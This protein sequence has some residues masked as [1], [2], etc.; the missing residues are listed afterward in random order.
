MTTLK[1]QPGTHRQQE[2]VLQRFKQNRKLMK[3][4]SLQMKMKDD[5]NILS[6]KNYWLRREA[7]NGSRYRITGKSGVG[8]EVMGEI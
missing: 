5:F 4:L 8:R 2:I 7:K 1:L 6:L 3:P